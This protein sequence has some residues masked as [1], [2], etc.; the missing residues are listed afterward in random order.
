MEYVFA[1]WNVSYYIAYPVFYI[2]NIVFSV[3]T[4]VTAPLLYLGHFSLYVC[5]QALR[6]LEKFEA[7]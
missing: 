2:L 6:I 5:W 4:I 7:S 1:A 3:L